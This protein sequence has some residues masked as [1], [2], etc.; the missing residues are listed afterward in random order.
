V[1]T[2][3]LHRKGTTHLYLEG[4]RRARIAWKLRSAFTP[5]PLID[6]PEINNPLGL[7]VLEGSILED[8]G[9]GWVLLLVSVVLSAASMA[10]RY[11][12]AAGEQR[13]Q[14]KWFTFAS[15]LVALSW[16]AQDA[17]SGGA[18]PLVGVFPLLVVASLLAMPVAV[19]IAILR[20]HL[21]DIDVV[22]NRTLVY[23]SLTVV[24]AASYEGGIV[25]LQ[26]LF[27]AF[28]GQESQVAVVAST[29]AIAALFEPLRRRIQDFVD[30]RFYRR[31][32]D[33]AK[34]LEAFS[35]RLRNETNL[36]ALSDNLLGVVRETMQPTHVSLWL[37]PDTP[38]KD[39]GTSNSP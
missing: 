35:A 13:Q 5:G 39:R 18:G 30:R 10:V 2:G 25:V 7:T 3:S 11:R 19:G 33:A 9:I 22:I 17:T 32:Y 28:T 26:H 21:Y 23:G 6:Y 8:G 16:V 29:L 24:L 1:S 34:T 20:H 15:V 14:I 4:M 31:K 36:H 12:R 37:R 38:P 27:R